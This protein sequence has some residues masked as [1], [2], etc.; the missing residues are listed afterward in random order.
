M[1]T[2]GGAEAAEKVEEASRMNSQRG[3]P[4]GRVTATDLEA[5]GVAKPSFKTT[6][7]G[8]LERSTIEN[9]GR[10]K[11]VTITMSAKDFR[12]LVAGAKFAP[13]AAE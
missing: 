5:V 10:N 4:K 1:R 3:K 8:I 6:V 11:A 9:P 13:A 2:V 12:E 7:R